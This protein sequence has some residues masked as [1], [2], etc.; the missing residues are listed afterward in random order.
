MDIAK[1]PNFTFP[2]NLTGVQA[3]SGAGREL[4]SG[5]YE[6]KTI[7]CYHRK[8]STGRDM[9]E[10]KS[11][12][13][14]GPFSGIV[15]TFRVNV[16]TSAEDGVRHY[17]RATLESHGYGAAQIDAGQITI[18]AELFIGRNCFLKYVAGDKAA[19]VWDETNAI[20][21]NDWQKGKAADVAAQTAIQG[22]TQAVQGST[23]SAMPA[24]TT[25]M[26]G[27]LGSPQNGTPAPVS[28]NALLQSLGA[29]QG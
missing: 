21:P 6:A 10:F 2:V 12:I 22:A 20:S 28:G 16:P 13:I 25:G 23:M 19:G 27:G 14:S 17:W 11:E 18:T 15:R 5:F 7:E 26:G 24:Q 3:A 1:N 29:P 9:I 4:P 8:S